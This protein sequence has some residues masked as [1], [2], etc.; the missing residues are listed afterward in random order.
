MIGGEQSYNPI[1]WVMSAL[2]SRRNN[3]HLIFL[4]SGLNRVKVLATP[5]LQ[6]ILR[7]WRLVTA[8][9]LAFGGGSSGQLVKYMRSSKLK[10]GFLSTYESRGFMR[11]T[12]LTVLRCHY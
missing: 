12:V 9:S 2:Q 10:F 7:V 5:L 1:Y 8:V 3:D 6:R 11:R 4:L